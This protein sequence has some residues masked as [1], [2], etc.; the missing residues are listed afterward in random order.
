MTYIPCLWT[1]AHHE[2]CKTGICRWFYCT[3]NVPLVTQ[4]WSFQRGEVLACYWRP[5]PSLLPT[6]QHGYSE[7]AESCSWQAG[8]DLLHDALQSEL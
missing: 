4:R 8:L 2:V 5:L 3:H 1:S 7:P 6:H